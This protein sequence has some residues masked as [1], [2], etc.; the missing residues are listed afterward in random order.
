MHLLIRGGFALLL[1]LCALGPVPVEASAVDCEALAA[2]TGARHGL[3][4]D[5]MPAI[6]RVETG[7]KQGENGVR[8]WPWTLNVQGKGY[9]FPTREAA[10]KKLREVLDSGVRNVDI[11]CMQINYRW[12]SSQF[13]S[14]EEMMSPKEN[15][16]YAAKFLTRLKDRHG[17]WEAATRHYHSA[18]GDR[19]EAYLN[20]VNRVVAKLPQQ[21]PSFVA[22]TAAGRSVTEPQAAAQPVRRHAEVTQQHG[23]LALAGTPLI[24]IDGQDYQ[25]RSNSQAGYPDLPASPLP[26]LVDP[27][28]SRGTMRGQ[29]R[30]QLV[31]AN[32][33]DLVARLRIEFAD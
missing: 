10:L 28:Q 16:E 4:R 33:H 27:K 14:I 7:L 19:G 18:D 32:R 29:R 11:G 1:G 31:S 13:S 26:K 15:T 22:S 23:V 8:A 30:A 25:A 5:L 20:R 12:H 6:S 21:Q 2:K 3:P 17:S 9:Y 24:D